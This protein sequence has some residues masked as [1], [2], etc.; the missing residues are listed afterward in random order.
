MSTLIRL[1]VH[2]A[3]VDIIKTKILIE[4]TATNSETINKYMVN[5]VNAVASHPF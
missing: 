3:S 2:V 4:K 5:S 1:D